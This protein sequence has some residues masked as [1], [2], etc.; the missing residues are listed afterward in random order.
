MVDLNIL[1]KSM[2]G[3][4]F[5]YFGI[6]G[7]NINKLLNCGIQRLLMNNIYISH[8]IIF[9]SIF[10]F[11]FILNWYTPGSLVLKESFDVMQYEQRY[12]YIIDSFKYSLLIYF[13]FILSTKQEYIFMITFLILFVLMIAIYI[14]NRI[15]LNAFNLKNIDDVFLINNSEIKN[16]FTK[17]HAP[18]K[19]SIDEKIFTPLTIY[20]NS[21]SIGYVLILINLFVGIYFYYK[22][23]IIEH[24]NWNWLTFIF[25]TNK[26]N[27]NK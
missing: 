2:I 14:L 19:T 25:G 20:H 12:T 9:V 1:N 5:L 18:K 3:F 21:L 10:I 22:R 26:C 6:I 8:M 16:L 4:F 13:V 17:N 23:Q 27:F 24:K 7:G 11:T 15:E